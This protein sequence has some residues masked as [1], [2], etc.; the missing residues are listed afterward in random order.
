MRLIDLSHVIEDGLVTYKGLPAPHVCDFLSRETSRANYEPGTEFQ[1]GQIT[2]VGNT[3]TY[4]DTPFHRYA[5]GEDLADVGLERLVDLPGLVVR[6]P[7]DGAVDADAFDGLDVAGRAVLVHTGWDRHWRTEAY[8]GN[9]PFLTE[10]AANWLAENGARLVGIDS[11]NIDDT[12]G[13]TR[14]VHSRL[15]GEGVLI[16]EHL[17]GLEQLPDGPFRF[18]AAPPKVKAFG[19]F[20]VR[21]FAMVD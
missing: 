21:A 3:G 17:R 4:L 12:R 5:E 18:F 14:P 7:T 19:T 8:Y 15:L 13:R 10:A 20:P 16:V 9:H 2:L 1:I 6:V 11:H